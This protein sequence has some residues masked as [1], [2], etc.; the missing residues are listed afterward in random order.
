VTGSPHT[1]PVALE[2]TPPE[3]LRYSW[4]HPSTA[5]NTTADRGVGR[6]ATGFIPAGTVL[7]AFGGIAVDGATFRQFGPRRIMHSIQI[8]DDLFLAGT[9][10][11]QQEDAFNHSCDPNCG[12]FGSI[13]LVAMRDISP[14]EELTYDYAMSDSSP[15]DEFA[16]SCD[17]DHCRTV[18]SGRDWMLPDLQQRY[19]GF[20]STYLARKIDALSSELAQRRVFAA[21]PTPATDPTP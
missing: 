9:E 10:Q 4:V 13:M 2:L 19:A 18:I 21:E 7:A 15:Y 5:T 8:D 17:T 11:T 16:C 14:G 12:M 6:V 3:Y 20:F 1:S